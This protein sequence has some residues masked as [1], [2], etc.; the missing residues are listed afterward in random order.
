MPVSSRNGHDR[1]PELRAAV[2]VAKRRR[3]DLIAANAQADNEARPWPGS[4]ADLVE[5]RL[6]VDAAAREA[7]R[8]RCAIDDLVSPDVGQLA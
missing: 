8:A 3:D 5:A 4:A 7:R 6:A 1:C 2:L